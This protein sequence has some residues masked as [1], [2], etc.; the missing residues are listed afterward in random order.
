M[1]KCSCNELKA[2]RCAWPLLGKRK[3]S[4]IRSIGFRRKNPQQSSIRSIGYPRLKSQR[5]ALLLARYAAETVTETPILGN[6]D[7]RLKQFLRAIVEAKDDAALNLAVTNFR[8]EAHARKLVAYDINVIVS[9]AP[10]TRH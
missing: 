1:L 5:A 7:K 6:A 3:R 8:G 9:T 10:R 2:R 4:F